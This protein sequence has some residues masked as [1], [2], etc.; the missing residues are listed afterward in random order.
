MIW[1]LVPPL[2]LLI[3]FIGYANTTG[4]IKQLFALVGAPI[5]VFVNATY[6][7]LFYC[8]LPKEWFLTQ[9]TTRL[10]S[11]TGWRGVRA[12]LFCRFL[13]WIMKDHCQ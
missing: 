7:S 13:N 11:N 8:E 3:A 2:L 1:L 5:D 6:G 12:K 9:R 10:R 4:G